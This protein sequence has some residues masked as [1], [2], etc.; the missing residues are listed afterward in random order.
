MEPILEQIRSLE[1]TVLVRVDETLR[2]LDGRVRTRLRKLGHTK[3]PRA[4]RKG[5]SRPTLAAA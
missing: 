1:V 4:V 2:F 5:K 3:R